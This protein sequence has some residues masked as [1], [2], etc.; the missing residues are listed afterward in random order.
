MTCDL[1]SWAFQV[2]R[3]R[4]YLVISITVMPLSHLWPH[5]AW[6]VDTS[7]DL[8]LGQTVGDFSLPFSTIKA[9]CQGESSSSVI[10]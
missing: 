10:A 3:I 4:K 2:Y 1:Q 5:L 9:S 7:K 6:Q 8:K